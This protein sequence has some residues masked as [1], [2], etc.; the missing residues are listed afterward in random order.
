M[1]SSSPSSSICACTSATVPVP[2]CSTA[3]ACTSGVL[4]PHATH[5]ACHLRPSWHLT[6][7]PSRRPFLFGTGTGQAASPNRGSGSGS[8]WGRQAGG[9]RGQRTVGGCANAGSDARPFGA[10]ASIAPRAGSASV[11]RRVRR[12]DGVARR[13]GAAVGGQAGGARGQR[14]VGGGALLGRTR[15]PL[16]HVPPS[17]LA[18]ARLASAGAC[19]G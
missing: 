7:S 14:N 3:T 18:P 19:V 12:I 6:L 11:R 17:R 4:V 5:V 9:A 10:H 13:A 15:G 2:S 8:S 1:A 16:E